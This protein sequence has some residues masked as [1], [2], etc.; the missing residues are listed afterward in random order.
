M[1]PFCLQP[2]HSNARLWNGYRAM[3]WKVLNVIY[4]AQLQPGVEN[5]VAQK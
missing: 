3:Q 2:L 1:A 5:S 4:P